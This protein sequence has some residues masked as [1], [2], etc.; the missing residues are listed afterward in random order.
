MYQTTERGFPEDIHSCVS[1]ELREFL[2]RD[3]SKVSM[4]ERM[5]KKDLFREGIGRE[6]C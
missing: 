3:P 2:D 4:A 5:E 1:K 6:F